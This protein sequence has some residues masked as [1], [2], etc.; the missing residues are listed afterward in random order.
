MAHTS[1]THEPQP[2]AVPSGAHTSATQEAKSTAVLSKAP[3]SATPG[4]QRVAVPRGTSNVHTLKK[5][6]LK[7]NSTSPQFAEYSEIIWRS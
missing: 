4:P 3:T 6:T 7:T 5:N 2:V 1:A